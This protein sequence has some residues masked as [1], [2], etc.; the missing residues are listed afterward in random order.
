MLLEFALQ[1]GR[2][3]CNTLADY[4]S[5]PLFSCEEIQ[6]KEKSTRTLRTF[7]ERMQFL[8][9]THMIKIND[10][11]YRERRKTKMETWMDLLKI[12]DKI[13]LDESF[14]NKITR[15]YAVKLARAK[16]PAKAAGKLI[17]R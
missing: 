1:C 16:L 7:K 10:L 17:C 5:A 8:Q 12:V 9:S 6:K 15:K 2:C 14:Q 4:G 13:F 11:L 3:N